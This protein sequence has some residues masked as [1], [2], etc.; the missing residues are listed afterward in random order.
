MH[1]HVPLCT[2]KLLPHRYLPGIVSFHSLTWPDT[3]LFWPACPD[4]N[5]NPLC[6]FYRFAHS[7][8]RSL[9]CL[10]L[11]C[12]FSW[13]CGR[14][15]PSSNNSS[16]TQTR[17]RRALT[18]FFARSVPDREPYPPSSPPFIGA[19]CVSGDRGEKKRKVL[20]NL[21]CSVVAVFLVNISACK[22]HTRKL[23]LSP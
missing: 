10:T 22:I 9:A 21:F 12:I 23:L 13:A 16:P 17:E 11:F 6:P 14:F 15:F 19:L 4:L 20:D 8:V 7:L 1:V 2:S 5:L 3:A 18:F